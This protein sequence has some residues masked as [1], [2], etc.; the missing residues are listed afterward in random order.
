MDT[1]CIY[2]VLLVCESKHLK[3]LS[4]P[5]H[6]TK[7]KEVTPAWPKCLLGWKPSASFWDH[8]TSPV[9]KKYWSRENTGPVSKNCAK[10]SFTIRRQNFLQTLLE[11]SALHCS[12]AYIKTFKV[13]ELAGVVFFQHWIQGS[14]LIYEHCNGWV[15]TLAQKI[16]AQ[17]SS[18]WNLTISC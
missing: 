17:M 15:S 2:M 5:H 8:I 9:L 1:P 3:T 14:L 12:F 4:L 11:C 10:T 18:L 6:N 7:K 13:K 16:F